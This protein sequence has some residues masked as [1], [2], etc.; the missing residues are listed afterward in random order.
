MSHFCTIVFCKDPKDFESLLAPYAEYQCQYDYPRDILKF[1]EDDKFD[2]D[3]E[4][5]KRGYWDNPQAI[6]DWYEEGGR[7]SQ[8]LHLKDGRCATSAKISEFS[9]APTPEQIQYYSR[10]WDVAVDGAEKTEKEER[11]LFFRP[12]YYLE[13]W[14]TKENYMYDMCNS[15]GF[16][17]ITPD[18]KL[19]SRGKPLWFGCAIDTRESNR[20]YVDEWQQAIESLPDDYYMVVVDCHI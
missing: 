1:V 5:N 16:H 9:L 11:E 3:P 13:R 4:K 12:E 2:I 20:Q 7:Y 17:F 18:G 15:W 19:H 14:G 10:E 6:W 8:F